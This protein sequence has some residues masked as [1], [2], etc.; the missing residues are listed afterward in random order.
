[1]EN[2]SK[3]NRVGWNPAINGLNRMDFVRVMVVVPV[4]VFKAAIKA[5]KEVDCVVRTEEGNDVCIKG[6][7]KEHNVMDSAIFMVGFAHAALKDVIERTV[8]M[9]NASRTVVVADVNYLF[10]ERLYGVGLIASFIHDTLFNVWIVGN[11][12]CLRVFCRMERIIW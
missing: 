11:V 5:H 10:V 8:E 2:G 3:E 7:R 9:V 4:V 6:V 1:M 12:R